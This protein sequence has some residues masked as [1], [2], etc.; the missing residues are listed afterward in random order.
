MSPR[1][2]YALV[3]LIVILSTVLASCAKKNQPS[4]TTNILRI[5]TDQDPKILN[6]F[7]AF[8]DSETFTIGLIYDTLLNNDPEK[9]L[10]PGLADEWS[11]GDGGMS[12]SFKLNPK[13]Q[14]HDGKPVTA[15][16]VVFTFEMVKAKIPQLGRVVANVTKV[17]AVN[18]NEVKFTLSQVWPDAPNYIGN[19]ISIV[20]KAAWEKVSDPANFPNLDKPIGSGPFMLKERAEGQRVVLAS[21]GKHYRIK[22]IITQI[23][24]DVVSDQ[25]VGMMALRKG[26]YDTVLWQVSPTLAL[27]PVQSPHLYPFM[28]VV[29]A[30]GTSTKTLL[31]NLR[32]PPYDDAKFRQAVAKAID[33]KTI[34]DKALQ[35]LADPLGPGLVASSA[36]WYNSQ[37]PMVTFDADKAVAELEAAGY[38]DTNKDNARETPDGKPLKLT[39]IAPS[40]QP[41]TDVAD[42][43]VANLDKVGIKAEAKP[44]AL[45]AFLQA[46]RI[47][48]F[49]AALSGPSVSTQPGML[50]FYFHSSRGAI[51][52][53]RIVG[54][55]QG[56]YNNPEFDK[57]ATAS[58]Q[59]VDGAKRKDILFQMQ[60]MIANDM[61]QVPLYVPKVLQ[62]Y[63]TDVLDGWVVKPGAG[64]LNIDS[65]AQLKSKYR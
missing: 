22:P 36:P 46:M 62:L 1:V 15:A 41:E 17:E 26:D 24:L 19:T 9:G 13:A 40:T 55:N 11:F 12:I 58:A 3:A 37:I 42:L 30:P 39:I 10:Q 59:E 31:F 52:D 32:K 47:G 18:K 4:T 45:D 60:A 5:A 61:P 20:P 49:E 43:I 38:K 50:F 6:P 54:F 44:L 48:D 33:T 14:W 21:T 56:G 63:R 16:D 34:I 64:I 35:G 7:L 25:T 29:K 8:S 28:E 2:R 51:T 27:A 53:G 23:R 65:Y 57:L